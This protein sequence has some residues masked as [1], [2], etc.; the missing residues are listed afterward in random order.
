MCLVLDSFTYL[1]GD[2]SQVQGL[3]KSQFTTVPL[4]DLSTGQIVEP[5]YPKTAPDHISIQGTLESNAV[6]SIAFRKAKSAADKTGLRWYITGTEGEIVITTEEGD[7]QFGHAS[8][9]SIKLKLSGEAEA[10]EVEFDTDSASSSAK[11]AFPGTNT[12]RLYESFS[13]GAEVPTFESALKTHRLL[14]RI[15]KSAGW[16][17]F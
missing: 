16:E 9:R 11:V 15:A 14:E 13:Q 8:E 17:S 7:W 12:A 4:I 3:L 6:A 5:A 1:L 2:F 10:Q